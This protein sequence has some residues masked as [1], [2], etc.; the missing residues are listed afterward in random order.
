MRA[1]NSCLGSLLRAP[2]RPELR[3]C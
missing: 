3:Y 2:T 1:V